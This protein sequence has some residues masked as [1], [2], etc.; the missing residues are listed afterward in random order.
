MV[1]FRN[2]PIQLV[3]FNTEA[4]VPF[5]VSSKGYGLLWDNNAWSR[6]NPVS[7]DD[8]LHFEANATTMTFSPDTD[9]H[10]VFYA[11]MCGDFGCGMGKQLEIVIEDAETGEEVFAQRAG[12]TAQDWEYNTNLPDS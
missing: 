4:V 9:G 6:L 5:F 10:Y 8:L 2:T 1:N 12:S 3:Q 7:D 11:D